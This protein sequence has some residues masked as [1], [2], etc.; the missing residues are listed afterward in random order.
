M[1]IRITKTIDSETTVLHVAGGL[2]SEDMCLLSTESQNI[3][4]PMALELSELKTADPDGVAMLREI[5]SL[6]AE[7]RGVTPYIDLLLKGES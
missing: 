1:T 3:D 4:G 6:G 5:A 2:M 7:L